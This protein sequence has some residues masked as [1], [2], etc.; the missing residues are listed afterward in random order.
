MKRMTIAVVAVAALGLAGCGSGSPA[1]TNG[2]GAAGDPAAGTGT[3]EQEG[4]TKIRVGAIPIADTAAV[5]LGADKG[6]FEDEGL[7][8]E[9][10]Q[11]A[12]GSVAVPGVMSGD[13]DFAFSN[14]ISMFVARDQ[15]LP[16]KYVTNGTTN[17][18]VEGEDIAAIV[19]AEDSPLQSPSDL[20]GLTVSSN[21]LSNIGDTT[22]RHA[23]DADGGDGASLEFVEIAV[24]DVMASLERGQVDAGL[25]VE[26]FLTKALNEGGRA[27][28]WNYVS[29]SESMD[30][31]GYFTLE[32]TIEE[33]AELVEKFTRA[34]ATSLEFADENPDEVRRIIQTYT[35]I[36]ADTAESMILPRF[37]VEFNRESAE[38]LGKAAAKYGTI[39]EEPDLDAVLPD[40][41][42]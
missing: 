3:A 12:G 22:I 7:D 13:F 23:V 41:T 9:I 17:T 4:L 24:P 28:G 6:F 18:G 36:D 42:P 14:I 20:N 39:S 40:G 11:I 31:S 10:V 33:D 1:G 19:V 30:V 35:A 29:V 21:L 27:I 38:T 16:I 8:I 25:I 34:M 32:K 5:F 37:K 15:G 2:T 26:P